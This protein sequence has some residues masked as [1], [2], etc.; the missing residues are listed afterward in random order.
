ME[1]LMNLVSLSGKQTKLLLAAGI[2]LLLVFLKDDYVRYVL[3]GLSSYAFAAL[4]L[5]NKQL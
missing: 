4:I 2:F 1:N 5:N 3:L